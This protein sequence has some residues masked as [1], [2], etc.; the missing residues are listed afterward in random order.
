M[1][2]IRQIVSEKGSEIWS[3]SPEQ[4]VFEAIRLMA[5]KQVGALLVLEGERL[6][7]I[8][9]ERDYARRVI[10]EGRASRE[11][12][13]AEICSSP[14]ITISPRATAEEGLALM[15]RQ[16]VRHLPVVENEQ[17]LGVVSIGDL[18]SAVIGDQ[19]QLIE[20]LERY[21]SG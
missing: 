20:Q 9:S 13:V 4:S 11:T 3:V 6:H 18:V 17:L 15:T 10:L 5:S 1:H 14:A 21:V 19:R 2:T 16:R 8:V 7:G 12:Q